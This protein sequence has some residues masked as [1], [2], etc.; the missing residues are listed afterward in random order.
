MRAFLLP[1]FLLPIGITAQPLINGPMPGHTDH[2]ESTI[3]L[4]CQGPC[5]VE[6]EYWKAGSDGPSQRTGIQQGDRRKAYAMEFVLDG[7]EPGEWYTYQAWVNGKRLVTP[8]PLL[9]RT[10]GLWKWRTDPPD[11]VMAAG[12]CAYINEKA[13]DRPDGPNGPYGGGYEIFNSIADTRP[14]LMLWLG[15]NAY[16]REPDWG[17]WTGYLHRYTHTR[18][19]PEMQRL[20]RST[21]HYAIWDDHDFGPNDA[22]G[23][24]INAGLAREA[25]DLFWPNPKGRPTGLRTN[26]TMFSWSDVDFF[27]LDDRTERIPPD[28]ST[29]VPTILGKDQIDWLIRALDQSDATFKI[30]ALGGQFLNDAALFE[31]YA[32]V[33]AERQEIIDRIHAEGIDGVVFLT[34]DRHFTELSE[35]RL[36]NGRMI[37]DLTVSPLTSRAYASKEENRLAVPGTR[38]TERNFALLGVSGPRKERTLTI[39]IHDT[40]GGTIWEQRI[41]ATTK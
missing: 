19:T 16:L 24:F 7:L 39:S 27:L 3:W 33:P 4:Q 31:N 15:D 1:L 25:F 20:L 41:R 34:G 22:D 21:Q 18:S 26:T 37:Y 2:F 23:S 35:M 38:V 8:D 13:Y 9:F 11:I 40:N 28:V 14:D 10:Q 29:A 12:S 30:V 36:P 5:N 32:T 6:L 17:S